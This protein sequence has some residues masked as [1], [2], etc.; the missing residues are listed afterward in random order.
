M[1]FYTT[2]ECVKPISPAAQSPT[3]GNINP[4]N[5]YW[6]PAAVPKEFPQGFNPNSDKGIP[7]LTTSFGKDVDISAISITNS[8]DKGVEKVPLLVVQ[9]AY[10]TSKAETSY[11]LY[12]ERLDLATDKTTNLPTSFPD[13]VTE[14]RL[15]IASPTG[16]NKLGLKV[17][18][19]HSC[20]GN[21]WF[22]TINNIASLFNAH[23]EI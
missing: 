14:V 21:T 20:E 15:Y 16:S 13:D 19:M 12:S 1:P 11:V 8:D 17:D 18:F 6:S 5:G 3:N 2:E 4:A 10:L 9:L 22:C 23:F 7:S